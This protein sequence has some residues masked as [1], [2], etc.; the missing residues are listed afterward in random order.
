[1]LY[2]CRSSPSPYNLTLLNLRGPLLHHPPYMAKTWTLG[3]AIPGGS[4]RS[5]GPARMHSRSPTFPLYERLDCLSSLGSSRWERST[6]GVRVPALTVLTTTLLH[7]LLLL[8]SSPFSTSNLF[9]MA[10]KNVPS[11]ILVFRETE[12][13]QIH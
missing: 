6:A 9:S 7:L 1:L 2:S 3:A 12:C 13:C 5:T 8:C 4:M 10:I 11:R